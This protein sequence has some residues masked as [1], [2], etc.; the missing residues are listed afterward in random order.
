MDRIEIT[1][2]T[3]PVDALLERLNDRLEDKTQPM[4]EI[5]EVLVSSIRWNFREQRSPSGEKWKPSRRAQR[6]GGQTLIDTGRLQNS[7]DAQAYPDR[8]EVGT[9]VPYAA[10]LQLGATIPAHVIRARNAKALR[11]V[12]GGQVIFRRSVNHPGATIEPREFLGVRDED[13]LEIEDILL[14]WL[15]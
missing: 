2:D 8:V 10:P 7:I 11:F 6:E 14:R 13:W 15:Q 9:N 12:I 4:A 5:G 1:V 3:S